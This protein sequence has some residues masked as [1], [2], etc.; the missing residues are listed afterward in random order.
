MLS[1]SAP[2]FFS[3]ADDLAISRLRFV[4]SVPMGTPHETKIYV[5]L[6]RIDVIFS[7]VY[8][9][10]DNEWRLVQERRILYFDLADYERLR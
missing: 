5:R 3:I 6:Q 9:D 7:I 2:G 4:A 10:S 8:R 1:S